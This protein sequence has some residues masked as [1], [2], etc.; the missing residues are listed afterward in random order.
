[1]AQQYQPQ[2]ARRLLFNLHIDF[3]RPLGFLS[4]SS[5]EDV[6]IKVSKT[7]AYVLTSGFGLPP[8]VQAF[9]VL[10][11][12][13][14]LLVDGEKGFQS[15]LSEMTYLVSVLQHETTT[16]CVCKSLFLLLFF[17][18]VSLHYVSVSHQSL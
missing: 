3:A 1:M 10:R 12:N 11:R 6:K 4:A 14:F 17:M 16:Y 8:P 9:F 5:M 13:L 7:R 18:V 2:W 15:Q